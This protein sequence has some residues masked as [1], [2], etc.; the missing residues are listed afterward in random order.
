MNSSVISTK[1]QSHLNDFLELI[2]SLIFNMQ[3]LKFDSIKTIKKK[4]QTEDK[5]LKTIECLLELRDGKPTGTINLHNADCF[6]N[7]TAS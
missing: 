2:M 6:E 1:I 5:P 3:T 4:K 7:D